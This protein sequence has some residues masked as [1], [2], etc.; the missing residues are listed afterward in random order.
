MRCI[1]CCPRSPPVEARAAAAHG[2]L[3]PGSVE[4]LTQALR[5]PRRVITASAHLLPPQVDAALNDGV[6]NSA[7]QLV[8]PTDPDELASVVIADHFDVVGHF[9]R[10]LWVTDPKTSEEKAVP[11]VSGLLHSGSEF[12]DNQFFA[13]IDRLSGCLAPLFSG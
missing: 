8:D 1:C 3:L 7:R 9:D 5:D 2:S 13:L 6:V 4:A 11:V 10:T 12:R